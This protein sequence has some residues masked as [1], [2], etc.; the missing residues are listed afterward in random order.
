MNTRPGKTLAEYE[1][2]VYEICCIGIA[3]SLIFW[4]LASSLLSIIL[5]AWWFFLTWP[6]TSSPR[7]RWLV[8]LFSAFYILV[9]AGTFY[10]ANR[11]EALFKVQQ[12]SALFVFPLIFGFSRVIT[13]SSFRR[14]L[15]SFAVFTVLGC[16]T[17][18]IYGAY[19]WMRTGST[20]HLYGYEMVILKDMSPFVLGFFCLVSISFLMHQYYRKDY[21]WNEKKFSSIILILFLTLFLLLL[22]NRNVLF[23]WLTIMAFFWLKMIRSKA[24]RILLP[25]AAIVCLSLAIAFNPSLRAQWNDL[26]DTSANNTIALDEDKSLGR[27]WGGKSIRLA[28]WKCSKD[29]IT[30]H[31]L[32]GVGTG[33][34]QDSLQAAYEKRKF[35]FASRYNRYNAHNQYVQVTIAYGII[36]FLVLACALLIPLGIAVRN[37]DPLYAL[38]L[39]CFIFICITESTLEL[40]KGV[41]AYSFF[42]ALFAFTKR[43]KLS[44]E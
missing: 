24:A 14:I 27:S 25:G 43:K 35:F 20:T 13:D 34:V 40:S 37:N 5:S 23:G 17:C 22:G 31:W 3:G 33:D 2:Q 11:A 9:L 44:D 8:F 6:K 36:G 21:I 16:S 32:T 18:L 39:I 29:I 38:F 10:S 28:I 42:N 30:D 41:I 1:K 26:V 7:T 15:K 19:A 12:Q 4:P